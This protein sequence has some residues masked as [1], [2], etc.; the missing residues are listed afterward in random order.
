MTSMDEFHVQKQ[1]RRDENPFYTQKRG[2]GRSGPASKPRTACAHCSVTTL[3]LH[4]S[5]SFVAAR[6]VE[7]RDAKHLYPIMSYTPLSDQYYAGVLDFGGV[8]ILLD[9]G[10]D[11]DFQNLGDKIAAVAPTVDLVLLSHAEL[12]HVGALPA[13]KARYGLAAPVFATTPT[14][15]NGALTLYEAWGGFRAA[16]GRA[17]AKE[18][19]TLDDVDAA[20]DKIRALKFDQPLSL[21][22]RGAGVVV[23]AH[24]AGHSVG[25]AYWR[26]SRGAD[27]VVYAVDVHHARERHVDGTALAARGPDRRPAVL[28]CDAGPLRGP[29]APAPPRR[30]AEDAAVDAAL[31]ALRH[32]GHALFPAEGASR[33]LELLLVL[34]EAW[35]RRNL[36]GA[37]DLVFVHATARSVLDFARSQLEWMAPEAQDSFDGTTGA[38]RGGGHPL[39]LRE[40]RCTSSVRILCGNHSSRFTHDSLVDL[41]AG[42]GSAREAARR[43]QVR[44]RR[45]ARARDRRGGAAP[46]R[47]GRRRAQRRRPHRAARRAA[48]R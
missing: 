24:R 18:L 4:L 38:R 14:I 12:R 9:C 21:R 17:A 33:A 39:A 45:A 31:S 29:S 25:G 11:I 35:R 2:A 43:A 8:R 3:C 6:A 37:Y 20:F 48:R 41:H 10:C 1:T 47:V 23:T 15:K 16:K 27:E 44:R 40:V 34:D 5:R 26:I 13:A 19:F 36:G 28:I 46:P 32:G 22:G 42:R 7:S 30:A